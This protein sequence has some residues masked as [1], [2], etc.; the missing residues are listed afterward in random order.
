MKKVI[1]IL[2]SLIMLAAC[3]NNTQQ[4]DDKNYDLNFIDVN[5]DIENAQNIVLDDEDIEINKAGTYNLSGILDDGHIVIDASEEDEI[6]LLLNDVSIY[7]DD[8]SC[9]Y[10]KK[11]K[12]VKLVLLDN[13]N[14]ILCDDD[15]YD[16]DKIDGTIYSKATLIIDGKGTLNVEANYANAIVSKKDLII[17]DGTINITSKNHGIEGKDSVRIKDGT[18]TINSGKHGIESANDKDINKGYVYIAG[19][20][21]DVNTNGDGIQAYRLLQV[22]GGNISINNC[23]EG[24]EGQYVII[25]DG[26]INITSIDDGINASDSSLDNDENYDKR[27]KLEDAYINI[28]G[29]NVYINADGDGVDSNGEINLYDGTLIIDGPSLPNDQAFDYESHGYVYGGNAL[30]IGSCGMAKSFSIGS[31][32]CNLLYNTKK[33]YDKDSNITITNNGDILFEHKSAKAFDS[34]LLT[35]PKIKD[36]DTITIKINDDIYEYKINNIVN[37]YGEVS[38]TPKKPRQ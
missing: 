25:N 29:G 19:G 9:I 13:T 2:I 30:M 3:G 24:L 1:T 37:S 38:F 4:I 12:L 31:K 17:L 14:N 10:I 20:S 33:Q 26:N 18:I 34:I 5:Y 16:E 6:I 15:E 22:D 36:K 27:I 35:S 28:C 7:S 23:I 32:Q 8:F 11:A 21:I